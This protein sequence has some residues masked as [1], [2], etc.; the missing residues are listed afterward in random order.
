M[1]LAKETAENDIINRTN[2]YNGLS[3]LM[4]LDNHIIDK[5][6]LI[7]HIKTLLSS[8]DKVY[9]DAIIAPIDKNINYSIKGLRH[10]YLYDIIKKNN[11]ILIWHN[12]N[13]NKYELWAT[14]NKKLN[15]C[16]R[17]IENRIGKSIL[18]HRTQKFDDIYRR[19]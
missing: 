10:K 9:Y 8:T 1:I 2:N 11:I 3:N 15:K 17:I 5:N 7:E 6:I 19:L 14:S 13:S 4:T 18:Y 12:K 16:K